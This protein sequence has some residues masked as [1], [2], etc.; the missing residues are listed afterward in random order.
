MTATGLPTRQQTTTEPPRSVRTA[1]NIMY[2]LIGLALVRPIAFVVVVIASLA[3]GNTIGREA[4]PLFAMALA[5][6]VVGWFYLMLIRKARKGRRWAW[7]TLLMMLGLLA[8]VGFLVMTAVSD[9][10]AIG[11]VMTAVPLI[12]IGLLAGP[13]NARAYYA[14]P[15]IH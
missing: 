3:R 6:I 14:R 12:L 1:T 4:M 7:I 9:G 15:Q 8:V 10:A 2:V 5:V 11:M 13:R